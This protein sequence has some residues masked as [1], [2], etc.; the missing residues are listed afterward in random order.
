MLFLSST[1]KL[2]Q[3]HSAKW[4]YNYCDL[5]FFVF[6]VIRIYDVDGTNSNAEADNCIIKLYT[7]FRDRINKYLVIYYDIV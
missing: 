3:N 7:K 1:D 5:V 6:L 2:C 4:S